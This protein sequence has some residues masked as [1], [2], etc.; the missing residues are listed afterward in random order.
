MTLTARTKDAAG[1]QSATL[2]PTNTT[3]KDVTVPSLTAKY[4]ANPSPTISGKAECGATVVATKT[5]G[6]NAGAQFS[7]LIPSGIN[8]DFAV[9][10]PLNG[11][12][13]V[14]YDVIATD[15]AGNA[16]AVVTDGG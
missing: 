9:Q 11:Y 15:R 7:G 14:T 4:K 8:Y 12:T 16:S 6:G 5:A 2:S 13:T 3:I 1:N 10:G